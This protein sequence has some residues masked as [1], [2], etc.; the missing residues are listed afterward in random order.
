VATEELKVGSQMDQM[1]QIEE[2]DQK[3]EDDGDNEDLVDNALIRTLAYLSRLT[4]PDYDEIIR[5]DIPLLDD[6]IKRCVVLDMDETLLRATCDVDPEFWEDGNMMPASY[7]VKTNHPRE[8]D[9]Y[10]IKVRLR[11]H[12]LEVLEFLSQNYA[13]VVFTAG[14]QEYAD[15]ILDHIDPDGELFSLRLYRHHCTRKN[16]FHIKDLRLMNNF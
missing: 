8:E 15:A 4:C 3:M 6:D 13:V 1:D 2:E 9:R 7:T 16:Q 5:H 12:A 10:K 11:P 14:T